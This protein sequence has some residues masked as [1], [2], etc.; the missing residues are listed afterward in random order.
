VPPPLSPQDPCEVVVL[1]RADDPY[2]SLAAEIAVAEG[3]PLAHTLVDAL[4]CDPVFL[5][6]VTSP[7]MLSDEVLIQFGQTMEERDRAVSSGIITASTLD[8]ARDL[9]LRRTQVQGGRFVA[10]NAA[11][12]SAHLDEGRILRVDRGTV[13]ALTLDNLRDALETADYL[14]FTG[15]G[16]SSYLRLDENTALGAADVPPLDGIVVGTGS[17]QT[18]R[19]WNDGSIAL[20]FLDR[21]AAAYAGFVFSPNEGYLI[22]E[23]DGLPFRYTWPE[24][25]V[26]HA[27]QMQNRGTVQG[28]AQFPYQFL[29]GDPRIALQAAPPYRQVSDDLEGNVRILTFQDVQPGVIP[30]RIPGG[31]SYHFV[32]VPGIT[33]AAGGD[34]FYNSKLQMVNLRDDKYVLLDQPG[35]DLTLRLRV[36]P[37]WTWF[38]TDMLLDSLD[39]TFIYLEQTGGDILVAVLALLLLLWTGW[40]ARKRRLVWRRVR[41][42]LA[43][44]GGAA[45]LQAGYVLLRLSRVTITSKAVAFSP[46]SIAATFVVSACGALIY[47]RARGRRGRVVALSTLTFTSWAPIVFTLFIT[48]AFNILAFRPRYGTG[49]Y[50]ARLGFLPVPAFLFTLALFGLALRWASRSDRP[51]LPGSL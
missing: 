10:V 30:L 13:E 21:G 35:G 23:F 33:A 25:P 42:A 43:V 39:H 49:L 20:G 2:D 31:A 15:H 48:G 5:L 34:P 40:Q 12:P 19:P 18:V 50:N 36:R 11:N 9:W 41:V 16:S 8:G 38:P 32:G 22:G 7:D 37:P 47:L 4:A 17:C 45:A 51:D 46:L 14:T 24:A 6:W 1:A 44:G 3:A 29:L 28:F 27:L 26:G